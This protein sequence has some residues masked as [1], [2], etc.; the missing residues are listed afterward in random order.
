MYPETAYCGKRTALDIMGE[1]EEC[2]ID[3]D[4]IINSMRKVLNVTSMCHTTGIS[5][6]EEVSFNLNGFHGDLMG[7]Y[8]FVLSFEGNPLW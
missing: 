2:T 4:S 3:V 8:E 1:S 7:A 6:E 5:K